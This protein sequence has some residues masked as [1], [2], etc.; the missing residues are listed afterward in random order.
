MRWESLETFVGVFLGVV[1]VCRREGEL[2]HKW[3]RLGSKGSAQIIQKE[4]L[5]LGLK[6]AVLTPHTSPLRGLAIKSKHLN[7]NDKKIQCSTGD[8]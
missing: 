2:R 3:L 4:A 8:V 6:S 7:I 1:N 5:I